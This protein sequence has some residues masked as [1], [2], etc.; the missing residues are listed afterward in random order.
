MVENTPGEI[1]EPSIT[2]SF[3]VSGKS[4][5]TDAFS[6]VVGLAPTRLWRQRLPHLKA[7]ADLPQMEWAYEIKQRP[8]TSLDA[9]VSEVLSP[10]I[11]SAERIK[12]FVAA[13]QCSVDVVC[14]VYGDSNSVVLEVLADT[15][16][17]LALVGCGLS[18]AL[19][20]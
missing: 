3:V 15:V 10:F 11:S 12:S 16:R 4:F 13:H 14:L 5:D 2:S 1:V 20:V 8:H 17:K 6:K 18:L 19:C 9:A 7:R